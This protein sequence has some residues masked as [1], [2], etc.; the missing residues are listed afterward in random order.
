M[1]A[2]TSLFFKINQE[3]KD[4]QCLTIILNLVNNGKDDRKM[5]QGLDFLVDN[6]SL[7]GKDVVEG[8]IYPTIN[9]IIDQREASV[10]YKAWEVLTQIV[11]NVSPK[12]A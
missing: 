10:K 3:I 8:F 1:K 4:F 2:F 9:N 6:V 12:F 11:R 7:F 5:L